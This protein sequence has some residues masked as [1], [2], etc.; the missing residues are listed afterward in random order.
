MLLALPFVI[1]GG[2][3]TVLLNI[4]KYLKNKGF[5]IT[6]ITTIETD[7]NCGDNTP[8]YEKITKDI[9]HLYKFLPERDMWKDYIHYLINSKSIN[10]ILIVGCEVLYH[11]LPEI[12]DKYKNIKVYD[13]LFNEFGHIKNNRKYSN[14]IDGNIVTSDL[15]KNILINDYKEKPEKIKVI[16][17]GVDT[18]KE[19][20]PDN[21]KYE[22]FKFKE[23]DKLIVSYF[24]RLS[25]EKNPELFVKIAKELKSLNIKFLLIGN[26]PIYNDI[27]NIIKNENLQDIIF[28]PGF[29]DSIKPYLFE[30]DIVLVTSKIEGI[31][32]I[33]LEAMSFGKAVIS[34]NVGGIPTVIK[35]SENGYLCESENVD[36]FVEKISNLYY[37]R[38]K[39]RDI[40]FNARK[41]AVDNLD[42]ANMDEEY[43]NIFK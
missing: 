6:I 1:I 23:S 43:Y 26:G 15:I 21:Y 38:K 30:T 7:N 35:D 25:E 20:N 24:G 39:L 29:V 16:I 42:I 28:F 3:D 13:Q 14:Y 34:S 4:V 41:Y 17:H 33:I 40:S 10:E 8:E 5:T 31:P 36:N 19:Y 32:I 22:T 9:Y 11:M 27:N 37:N 12:K 2:A 18:L